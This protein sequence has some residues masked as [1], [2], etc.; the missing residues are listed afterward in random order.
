M[1]GVP[2][3]E[4][5]L[6]VVG[7]QPRE[8]GPG[9]DVSLD[10]ACAKIKKKNYQSLKMAF[11]FTLCFIICLTEMIHKAIHFHPLFFNFQNT[12]VGFFCFENNAE[13]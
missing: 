4:L 13:V 7:G 3:A 1:Q 8:V 10:L 11:S 12:K 9:A 2:D 5:G 6:E